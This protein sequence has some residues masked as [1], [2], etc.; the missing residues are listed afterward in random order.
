VTDVPETIAFGR[1]I[2]VTRWVDAAG[3]GSGHD[4]RSEY[5]ERY[6]LPILGPPKP[7]IG[8]P[9]VPLGRDEHPHI[10]R[11][12]SPELEQRRASQTR[13]EYERTA[14]G[15]KVAATVALPRSAHPT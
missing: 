6:W 5:V 11:G 3:E 13:L 1:R 9:S 10:V 7:L 15:M 12:G 2:R 4:A 8:V 14:S